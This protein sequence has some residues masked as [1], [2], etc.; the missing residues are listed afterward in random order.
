[1]NDGNMFKFIPCINVTLFLKEEETNLMDI[2]NIKTTLQNE[3]FSL[4]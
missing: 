1:M 2:L 4:F 3:S